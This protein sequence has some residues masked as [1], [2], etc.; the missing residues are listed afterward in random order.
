MQTDEG[1]LAAN[2]RIPLADLLSSCT[3][4][5]TLANLGAPGVVRL[6]KLRNYALQMQRD[7]G[8]FAGFA[9][10]PGED[11]EYTFYG[12]ATLALSY[13]P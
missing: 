11:V 12:L 6:D 10:D 5:I 3:G 13:P 8:G 1:G 9:L 7:T 2:T 4:L